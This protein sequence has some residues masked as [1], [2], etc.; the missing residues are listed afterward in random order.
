MASNAGVE[1]LTTTAIGEKG[2]LTVPKSFRDDL[3]LLPGAA[4]AVLR[5]GDALV[6][7]PEQ[8]RLN[9]LCDR[10]SGALAA[11]GSRVE[12]VLSTLPQTRQRLYDRRYGRRRA[13]RK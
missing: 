5:L 8:R 12:A 11:A 4:F 1:Y 2:Q 9:E 3:H 10:I 7:L 13:R 6:L